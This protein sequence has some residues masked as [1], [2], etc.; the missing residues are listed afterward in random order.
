[1]SADLFAEFGTGSTSA[2]PQRG[3][4][5][6][7]GGYQSPSLIPDLDPFEDA[8]SARS[9][10]GPNN[11]ATQPSQAGTGWGQSAFEQSSSSAWPQ[12]EN[13]NDVLF[14]ATVDVPEDGSDDWGEFET[15]E[16]PTVQKSSN[17]PPN[18]HGARKKH[19]VASPAPPK[20][21][22][23][24]RSPVNL[25]DML[26]LD[27]KVSTPKSKPTAAPAQKSSK[28]QRKVAAVV[29]T[30]S[31]M[32]DDSFEEWGDFVDGPLIE[33]SR[34]NAPVAA[35]S[36]A[37][38]TQ[39]PRQT[40]RRSPS[41]NTIAAAQSSIFQTASPPT[42]ADQVRPTNI[43][44]PSVLLE[45]FPHL[46]DELRQEATKAR[47]DMQQKDQLEATANLTICILKAAARVVAGRTLR[48]K[49]DSILSQSMRIG[50]AR[51]GKSGGMKLNSVNKNEDIKEQQ[52]AVDVL[53]MW[54]DRTALFNS[55]IQAT[56]RR[57]IQVIPENTRVMTLTATQGAQKASHACALCGLKRDERLPKIDDNVEDSFGE[58]WTDHWGHTDCRQFWEKN[59]SLLGQR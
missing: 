46:L 18:S 42:T 45:L 39:R 50:P 43:P 6:Q 55:I 37:P 32:P 22:T 13:S 2:R 3:S 47:K 26:S 36:T 12:Y 19:N 17:V 7:H 57:A 51:A 56:G 1:M 30:P 4:R 21:S 14:D 49:R 44:P 34:T 23:V 41:E 16:I 54:R 28:P 8:F 15:A 59:K 11:V 29:A 5:Q 35:K 27:D 53:T 31:P 9:P 24:E 40:Q 33:S 52:E 25:M 48:W 38:T 20:R 58:W 10:H